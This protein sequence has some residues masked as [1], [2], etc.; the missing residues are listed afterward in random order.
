[1][2]FYEKHGFIKL[3]NVLPKHLL[4]MAKEIVAPWIDE[5][6]EE[7]YSKSLIKNKYENLDFWNRFLEA[8]RDAKMPRFRRQPNKWLIC[9]KMYFFLRDNFFLKIASELLK[10]SEISVHGIFN[11]RPMFPDSK[12]S[13]A[14]PLH[15]A[16]PFTTT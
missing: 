5:Q 12:F 6:I 15:C 10:S 8:W 9:P 3:E 1:M 13:E 2:E 14:Q 11:A 4:N 7:W 16:Y